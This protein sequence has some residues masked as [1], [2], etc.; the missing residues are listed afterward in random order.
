MTFARSG[1]IVLISL[2]A[3]AGAAHWWHR[4]PRR[5]IDSYHVWYHKHGETTY[6][7]TR[8]LG[9]LV[10]KSPLDLW[11]FQEILNEVRPDVLVEAGTFKGGSAYYFASLFDLM[12]RGRILTIDIEDLPGKPQHPR[13]RFLHGSSTA[14]EIVNA[15]RAA[16]APGE[17]VMVVLDSDHRAQHVA[18]EL[19]L[20]SGL[21]SPGGYLIVEDTHFNG[22]PILPKYGPGPMEAVR[23]FLA[24]NPE[25]QP[26]RS[27]EKFGMT[28]NPNG[29]LKRVR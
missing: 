13:I 19:K 8:W 21:V 14:P 20:Y 2:A 22:H 28:F 25:F 1:L 24:A 9:A 5:M 26:D 10:Q 27:R 17:K 12:G 11:V 3:G 15:V 18:Q 7:N 16:I 6:N 23:E 29:Y 4:Q